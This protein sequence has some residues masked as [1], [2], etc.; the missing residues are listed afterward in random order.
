MAA[1]L[2]DELKSLVTEVERIKIEN[3]ASDSWAVLV[4]GENPKE[5]GIGNLL[6]KVRAKV[7][8]ERG[9]GGESVE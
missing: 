3:I 4:T 8:G 5:R 2:F 9:S 6:V 1:T 7:I